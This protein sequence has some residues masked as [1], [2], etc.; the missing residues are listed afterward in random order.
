VLGF[1]N[2]ETRGTEG[3]WFILFVRF[4]HF[5]TLVASLQLV[6]ETKPGCAIIDYQDST[7]SIIPQV[8]VDTSFYSEK[9]IAG[10][11]R[12]FKLA[13]IVEGPVSWN[14]RQR[15]YFFT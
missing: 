10:S 15:L 9:V 2:K 7:F 4:F 8:D 14:N 11:H 5:V 3:R 13:D 1:G 6:N 12:S